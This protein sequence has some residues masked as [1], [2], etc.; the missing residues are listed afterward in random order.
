MKVVIVAAEQDQEHGLGQG[1]QKQ[2]M[3]LQRTFG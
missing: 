1:R 3:H 2:W